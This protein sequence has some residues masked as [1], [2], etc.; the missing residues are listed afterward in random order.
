M[1]KTAIVVLAD[2]KSGGEEALGRVFNAMFLA[3]ELKEKRQD[4]AVI[5]Q[6]AGVR[7][8]AEL[9]NPAHPANPLYQAI[10]DT[11]VGVCGGCADVFGA[12]QSV[13][14]SGIKL[15]REKEIPGTNGIIDLS[16]Y[17]DDGYSLV[18][19]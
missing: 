1:S 2:P 6:G 13:V 7:W 3:Y 18:T 4:V 16:K 14:D 5:F 17:V 9:V 10:A 15:V 12:T 19:F 11:V 8:A